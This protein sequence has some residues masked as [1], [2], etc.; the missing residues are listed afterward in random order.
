MSPQWEKQVME[1]GLVEYVVWL[2]STEQ[3]VATQRTYVDGKVSPSSQCSP[4]KCNTL[5]L[6]SWPLHMVSFNLDPLVTLIIPNTWIN[7]TH[8]SDFCMNVAFLGGALFKV[9]PSS[10]VLPATLSLPVHLSVQSSG[11]TSRLR[12]LG[13]Q[14]PHL[15]VSH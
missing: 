10:T 14:G 12:I 15:T 7:P 3:V 2:S 6:T 11:S 4:L 9:R 5:L 13:G 8:P 1:N